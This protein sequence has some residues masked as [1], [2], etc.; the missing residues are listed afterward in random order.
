MVTSPV[1]TRV[2]KVLPVVQLAVVFRGY[3]YESGSSSCEASARI[4]AYYVHFMSARGVVPLTDDWLLP[5]PLSSVD[6]GSWNIR[7]YVPE[8]AACRNSA[9]GSVGTSDLLLGSSYILHTSPHINSYYRKDKQ[10]RYHY[11]KWEIVNITSGKS[12]SVSV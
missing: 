12:H 10:E 6:G 8:G 4:P 9:D 1:L 2:S 11:L 7:C 3:S 5:S